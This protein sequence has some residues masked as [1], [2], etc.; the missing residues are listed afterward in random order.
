VDERQRGVHRRV[1]EVGEV[2]SDLLGHEHA[3]VDDGPEQA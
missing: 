2:L 1:G 3:L